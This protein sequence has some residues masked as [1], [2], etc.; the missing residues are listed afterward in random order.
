MK[1]FILSIFLSSIISCKEKIKKE[2]VAKTNNYT[3]TITIKE[4]IK[5]TK[6]V[7]P[8]YTFN[9]DFIL[10]KFNFKKDTSF[11]KVKAEHSSKTLYLNK[12]VYVAFIKMH[13][14][15]KKEGVTL[16]VIS[17]TRNFMQ[18]K[19]IWE[20]KWEK[21]KSIAPLDR[22]KKILEYSSMPSTSRHHWGTDMDINNLNNS[23]FLSGKGKKEYEWLVNN[24]N[25]YGFYQVYTNKENVFKFL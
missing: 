16:I 7:K 18:Q 20:R 22:A 5:P 3:D 17:G 8:V 23:Y 19:Y 15:A 24:A 25:D 14:A 4:D 9:N 1:K 6:L 21:Y 2:I 10:G 11:T 13:N 12:E